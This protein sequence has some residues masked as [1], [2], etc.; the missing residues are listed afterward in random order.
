MKPTVYFGLGL[1]ILMFLNI[2]L[3]GRDYTA[4]DF[5]FIGFILAVV[6]I[7]GIEKR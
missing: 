5:G 3:A 7:R 1:L 4:L 6:T 2:E